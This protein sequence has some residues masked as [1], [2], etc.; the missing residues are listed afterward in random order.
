MTTPL[1]EARKMATTDSIASLLTLASDVKSVVD[2]E[3]RLQHKCTELESII[4]SCEEALDGARAPKRGLNNEYLNVAGRIR[5]MTTPS[6]VLEREAFFA[7]EQLK[8][9]LAENE[10]LTK[11][12]GTKAD[13]GK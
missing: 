12:L 9:V 1:D 5:H 7:R 2:S 6:Y 4:Q 8:T 13:D 10:R 3:R 11:L